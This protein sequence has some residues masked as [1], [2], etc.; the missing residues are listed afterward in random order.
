M[1]EPRLKL[2]LV[3]VS[4][5]EANA[6]VERLHRHHKPVR[7]CKFAIGVAFSGEVVGVAIVGRPVARRLDD[8]VTLE[9]N[10]CATDGTRNACSFLYGRS[11]R[12]AQ[13]LGYQRLIT[14]TLP[15][16]GGASLRGAG[17][18]LVGEAGGGSWSRGSR[19]RVDLHPLQ[20]KLKWQ[21][22][23]D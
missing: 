9:V 4:L 5:R 17:W 20:I 14:Y 23:R 8:G 13:A 15:G 16:E 22:T 21:V 19:P 1:T 6:V 2:E 11:W 12:A 3:P 18:S 7:G 10:R